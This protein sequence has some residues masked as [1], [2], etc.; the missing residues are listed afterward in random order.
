MGGAIIRTF[1]SRFAA[2]RGGR[3][4]D[5]AAAKDC[6]TNRS[7]WMGRVLRDGGS[8]RVGSGK[9]DRTIKKRPF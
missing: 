7:G 5:R 2:G 3:R 6:R 8:V 9:A 1:Q 4:A